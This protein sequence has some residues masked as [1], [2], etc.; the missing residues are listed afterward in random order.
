MYTYNL[1]GG[2]FI[3]EPTVYFQIFTVVSDVR[4]SGGDD[5]QQLANKNLNLRLKKKGSDDEK[6]RVQYEL[7]S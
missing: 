5:C 1:A 7:N 3:Y 6:V 4:D 2:L